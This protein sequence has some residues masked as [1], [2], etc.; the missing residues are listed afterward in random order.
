[1]HAVADLLPLVFFANSN[2]EDRFDAEKIP[3]NTKKE[4]N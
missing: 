3:S 2:D 4:I 1:M